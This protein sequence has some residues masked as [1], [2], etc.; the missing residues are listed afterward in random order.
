[1][2]H[3]AVESYARAPSFFKLP[4]TVTLHVETPDQL[5]MLSQDGKAFALSRSHFPIRADTIWKVLGSGEDDVASKLGDLMPQT[6]RRPKH[7]LEMWQSF[8][9]GR[10][11]QEASLLPRSISKIISQMNF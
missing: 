10:K 7:V 6:H 4:E 8:F 2:A 5:Q 3:I 1:M 11:R 9:S